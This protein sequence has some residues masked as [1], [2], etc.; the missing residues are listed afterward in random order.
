M[1]LLG[2]SVELSSSNNN[3]TP[4]V[5]IFVSNSGGFSTFRDEQMLKKCREKYSL[6]EESL[7]GLVTCAIYLVQF[8]ETNSN[9]TA[10]KVDVEKLESI[11]DAKLLAPK[12][13]HQYNQSVLV[14]PRYVRIYVFMY[15][16]VCVV[17]YVC[18]ICIHVLVCMNVC[19]VCLMLFFPRK[20]V[21]GTLLTDRVFYMT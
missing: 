21:K 11:L 17:C 19:G 1:T 12:S 15:V 14:V 6:T 5:S 16:C 4:S 7:R 2:G 13:T 9:S 3:K 20:V 8:N 10:P 18:Y